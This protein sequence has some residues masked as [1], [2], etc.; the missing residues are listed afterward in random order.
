L[1]FGDADAQFLAFGVVLEVEA[2]HVGVRYNAVILG[3]AGGLTMPG[4]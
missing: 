1:R 4:I 3:R 2:G